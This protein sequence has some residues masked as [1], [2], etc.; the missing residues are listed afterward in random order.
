MARS[1]LAKSTRSSRDVHPP[2]HAAASLAT[3]L[4]WIDAR[5]QRANRPKE[6]VAHRIR[7]WV[8]VRARAGDHEA[9]NPVVA[10]VDD[11][12]HADRGGHRAP[13]VTRE[14]HHGPRDAARL[15]EI[16]TD[17]GAAQRGTQLHAIGQSELHEAVVVCVGDEGDRAAP[18]DGD[19]H[20]EAQPP[21]THAMTAERALVLALRRKYLREGCVVRE[22]KSEKAARGLRA[23]SPGA[24]SFLCRQR[25]YHH[26][27]SLTPQ[28]AG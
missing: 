1:T 24:L 4:Y 27:A 14:R 17:S 28:T 20:R 3:R 5:A 11:Y 10:R 15:A 19:A 21:W 7:S 22:L 8:G 6:L 13:G 25:R 16:I 23:T 18:I 26:Q 9:H 2:W 12:D